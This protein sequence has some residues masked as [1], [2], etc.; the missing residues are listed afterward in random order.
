MHLQPCPVVERPDEKLVCDPD[1]GVW[2]E[3]AAGIS[4]SMTVFSSERRTST[5][6][7]R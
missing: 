7:S 4:R 5:I 3:V 2:S 1:L 6:R